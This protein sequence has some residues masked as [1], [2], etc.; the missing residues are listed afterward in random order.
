MTNRPESVQGGK[1][2]KGTRHPKSVILDVGYDTSMETLLVGFDSAWTAAKYGAVVAALLDEQGAIREL[3]EPQL[4]RYS[5]AAEA[6]RNWQAAHGPSSTL[7]FV[8]QP[9]IV[10]NDSGQ[11]PVEQ[12]VC[13]AVSR[14]RGGMQPA[15]KGRRDMFGATAP[16]WDFLTAF[17]GA[18]DPFAEPA[19]TSVFET[20]PV[21]AMISLGWTLP[22]SQRA[23]ERLPKYNPERRKTFDLA[24]WDHVCRTTA[25]KLRAEGAGELAEW[26]EAAARNPKPTKQ[27]QDRLDACICLL[28]G[29]LLAKGRDAL[30]VGCY[31]TGYIAIPSSDTLRD[32]LIARCV[33]VGR[34]PSS[35]VRVRPLAADGAATLRSRPC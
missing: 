12:L 24:D 26:T 7:V 15:N 14:R 19:S 31:A 2:P 6:I 9:T 13:S 10:A 5:A 3:G 21:L 11:R 1:P 28:V 22:D 30:I 20:Y 23:T 18:A 32:E 35:W 33:Q 27:D 25:E 4:V 29:L 8:D 16:V 17:G 34:E